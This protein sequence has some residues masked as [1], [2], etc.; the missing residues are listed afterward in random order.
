MLR[1]ALSRRLTIA[2]M[3]A[4]LLIAPAALAQRT[5]KS[6]EPKLPPYD[7]PGVKHGK[8]WAPWVA[9]FLFTGACLLVAFKNPH[10]SHLD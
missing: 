2:A 7:V 9:A 4:G 10:R 5:K 8:Q 6:D 1:V 3:L